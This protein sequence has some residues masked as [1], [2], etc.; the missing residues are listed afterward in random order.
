MY[1]GVNNNAGNDN[2]LKLK[3]HLAYGTTN[4]LSADKISND[5]AKDNT[6]KLSN[7]EIVDESSISNAAYN[8][9]ER[10]NDIKKFK[11]LLFQ[12]KNTLLKNAK[13]I[14]YD[15]ANLDN[16]LNKIIDNDKFYNDIFS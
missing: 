3:L 12:D 6:S 13:C 9:F 10:E 7:D 5:A 1:N 11:N 14:N 15:N 4:V 2:L 16:V 8:I